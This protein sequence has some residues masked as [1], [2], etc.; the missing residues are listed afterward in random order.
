LKMY[1]LVSLLLMLVFAC[2]GLLFLAIPDRVLALFNTFS[3]SWGMAQSPLTGWHF[4]LVLAA[5][6]M[7]LVTVLAFL[8]FKHP[9][10]RYFALLLIHAKLASSVLSLG[11]FLVQAHYL[12][13][14]VNFIIDGIIGIVVLALYLKRGSREWASS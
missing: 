10:N 6:Y 5:G 1:K 13:Y 14:L 12:I 8:M 3:A 9:E 7:Y 4:Y 11:F 2:T